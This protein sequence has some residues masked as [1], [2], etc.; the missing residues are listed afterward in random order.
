MDASSG[1]I[2]QRGR[3]RLLLLPRVCRWYNWAFMVPEANDAGFIDAILRTGYPLECIYQRQR[4]PTDR[5]SSRI[6]EI[7]FETTNLTRDWLIAAA[8]DAVRNQT[9]SIVSNVVL[10]ECIRFVIKPNGKKE[11]Q[12]GAHDDCVFGLAFAEIGRRALPRRT[13]IQPEQISRT[14]FTYYGRKRED[15]DDDD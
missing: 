9:I 1:I 11:H 13:G 7:G 6:E 2:K 3:Q 10:Q 5:R 15:D 8:E 4:D 14:R 12:D